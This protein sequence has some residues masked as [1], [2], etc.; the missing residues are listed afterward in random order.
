MNAILRIKMNQ[1]KTLARKELVEVA[2]LLIVRKAQALL[3]GCTDIPLV[4]KATDFPVPVFDSNNLLAKATVKFA[5]SE[6]NLDKRSDGISQ[7][8]LH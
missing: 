3:L 1:G 6:T 8:K 4:I 7:S 2:N 5:M